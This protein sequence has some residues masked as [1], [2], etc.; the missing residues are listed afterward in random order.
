MKTLLVSFNAKFVHSSLALRYIKEFCTEYKDDIQILELTINHDEN[1]IIKSIYNLQPDIIGF[2]CYIWNIEYITNIIPTLRKVLPN[3]TFILGGP[4]VTY[5]SRN[6][7]LDLPIDFV[8]EGEGEITWQQY[9]DYRTKSSIDISEIDGLIYKKNNEIVANKPRKP[10]N[11]KDLPFV[12]KDMTDLNNKIIYY[13]ASRGCPFSCQYCLSSAIAGVRFMPLE[14]VLDDL[15]Y[16]LDKNLP[17]VKFVDRTFNANKNFAISIWKYIID[18][19]NGITNFHFEIAAEMMRDEMFEV[20]KNAREGLIQFE[21]GVQSTNPK[22]LDAI[23][24]PMPFSEIKKISLKIEEI[25]TIH[26]HLDLIVGLP[27]EDYAS[28]RNSFNEVIS[29]RPEQLQLGFLKVLKGSGLYNDAEKY[30]IVYKDLPPYEVL[31]TNYLSYKEVL[32]LHLVEEMLERYYNSERFEATLE[33]LF[34]LYESPFDFFESIA[35]Y[36]D[37]KGYDKVAHK[38]SAYYFLLLEFGLTIKTIDA[39]LLKELI[40]WDWMNHE[41]LKE[42]QATLNTLD[43]DEF[44]QDMH[45]KLKDDEWV[46]KLL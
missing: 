17:Q 28:F 20:L 22:T 25:G 38:K 9:L 32:K 44:K 21:I 12:Y 15:Q 35:T 11:M 1:Q 29:I 42:G 41:N 8:M 16:F 7:V 26:Q 46:I 31:Y 23:K 2:S 36:W 4:E 13:E 27:Y 3:T 24:R 10:L 30:G 6:L 45:D 34:T 39:V 37:D 43:Q 33:Y 18:N 5:N 40:R 19:D 14:R